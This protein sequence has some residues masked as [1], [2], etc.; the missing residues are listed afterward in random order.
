MIEEFPPGFE[1]DI[2]NIAIDF[3]GVIHSNKNGYYDGT[4]YGEPVDGALE[5]IKELSKEYQIIIFSAKCKPDRPLI[6]ERTG[7]QLILE[8]LDEYGFLNYI[9]DVTHEKPRAVIYIDDK[10]YHF[11]SWLE[12]LGYIKGN[13]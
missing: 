13:L 4:C 8:W 6:N 2:K 7:Q 3:D 9:S 5:A 11:K 10:G 1:K 12:T